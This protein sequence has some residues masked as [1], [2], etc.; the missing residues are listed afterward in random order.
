MKLLSKKSQQRQYVKYICIKF[1]LER[2][3]PVFVACCSNI[4]NDANVAEIILK[5]MAA[6][7]EF[8]LRNKI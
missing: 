2:F 3:I 7:L 6:S 1:L 8:L 4:Q 5:F